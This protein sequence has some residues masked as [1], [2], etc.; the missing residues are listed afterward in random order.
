MS[1]GLQFDRV[2]PGQPGQALVCAA[3][4]TLLTGEYFAAQDVKFCGACRVMIE[5]QVGSGPTPSQIAVAGAAGLA[6]AAVVDFLYLSFLERDMG[7]SIVAL[8]S[9][10]IVGFAV[11][12]GSGNRGG[13]ACQ[14]M[15]VVLTYA[16]V[17]GAFTGD[18]QRGEM[19]LLKWLAAPVA[20]GRIWTT[21]LTGFGVYEAWRINTSPRLVFHG[22]FTAGGK[23]A[24]G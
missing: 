2:E 5:K 12:K 16:M 18:F 9:G 17:V 15:A 19:T 13:R 6:V 24:N 11:R 14:I 10:M 1:D 23:A 3:C 8:F 20:S 7:K 22:P 21:V 4:K